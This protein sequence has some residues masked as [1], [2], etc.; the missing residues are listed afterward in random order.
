VTVSLD[1]TPA[2]KAQ[3]PPTV[4]MAIALKMLNFMRK[5]AVEEE[6]VEVAGD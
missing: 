4:A 5:E 1:F 6:F 3:E 2:A